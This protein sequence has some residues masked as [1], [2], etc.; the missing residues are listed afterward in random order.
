VT[1]HNDD[2]TKVPLFVREGGIV[3]LLLSEPD[4]HCD[5]NY[6]NNA[7]V[8]APDNGLRFLVYPAGTSEFTVYDGTTLQSQASGA[9]RLLTLTSAAR[10]VLLQI[11]GAEPAGATVGG[12]SLQKV[13]TRAELAGAASGWRYDPAGRFVYIKF[14]HAGGATEV[15]F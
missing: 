13:A 1:W 15:R 9:T 5:A 3:P 7:N 8:R 4:T 11:L 12:V 2:P 6:V 10:P 14:P